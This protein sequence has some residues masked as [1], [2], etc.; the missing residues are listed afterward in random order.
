M[1]QK[2]LETLGSEQAF[3]VTIK[4][5]STIFQSRYFDKRSLTLAEIIMSIPSVADL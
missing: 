3:S 4:S 2:C 1:P 5:Q